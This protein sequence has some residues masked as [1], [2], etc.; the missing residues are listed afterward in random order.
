MYVLWVYVIEEE[1]V[2]NSILWNAG[3]STPPPSP[4]PSFLWVY[5]W[6]HKYLADNLNMELSTSI[7]E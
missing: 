6:G 4:H 2:V 5:G 7:K 3:G 1:L